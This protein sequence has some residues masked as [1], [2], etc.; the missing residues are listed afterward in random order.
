MATN[1]KPARAKS[2]A[3]IAREA[4]AKLDK[5]TQLATIRKDAS[6]SQTARGDLIMHV[7]TFAGRVNDIDGWRKT[8]GYKA[9]RLA[10]MTG[11]IMGALRCTADHAKALYEGIAPDSDAKLKKG[12]TRRT[13]AQQKA[14][15]NAK[16]WFALLLGDC[17][18]SK[19]QTTKAKNDK[20]RAPRQPEASDNPT[21]EAAGDKPDAK[22]E[23]LTLAQVMA[24]ASQAEASLL[25]FLE[26]HNVKLGNKLALQ[27]AIEIVRNA[28]ND[29]AKIETGLTA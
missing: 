26:K 24:H 22:P 2:D 23:K 13:A 9:L 21:N 15:D 11:H 16:K 28:K 14:Y 27:H 29:L 1:N 17:G 10:Y 18:L 8:D 20:Q 3:T 7:Q 19:G 4:F 12:Q 6:D 25:A 5:A